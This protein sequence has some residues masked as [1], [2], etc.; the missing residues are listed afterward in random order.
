MN[1]AASTLMAV[2]IH[3]ERTRAISLTWAIPSSS[4]FSFERAMQVKA[5]SPNTII[6]VMVISSF[7]QVNPL[8]GFESIMPE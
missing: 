6:S 2:V 1:I 7:V 3:S 8:S 4:V 5:V